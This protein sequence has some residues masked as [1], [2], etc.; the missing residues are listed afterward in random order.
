MRLQIC[1]DG[2]YDTRKNGSRPL[3]QQEY[4]YRY[5][6][7]QLRY[8][9][10]RRIACDAWNQIKDTEYTMNALSWGW[11]IDRIYQ[12]NDADHVV[13]RDATEGENRARITSSIITGLFITG[14]DYS[15][16]GSEEVKNRARTT[17]SSDST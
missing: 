3:V 8:A 14:D 12:Y 13:L 5:R 4:Q 10:S 2:F 6:G 15:D 16:N 17:L 9:Q 11:W 1:K 7:L